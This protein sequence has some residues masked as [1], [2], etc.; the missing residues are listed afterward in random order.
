MYSM[1]RAITMKHSTKRSIL[2]FSISPTS[3]HR[4]SGQPPYSTAH[5]SPDCSGGLLRGCPHSTHCAVVC[6]LIPAL[7]RHRIPPAFGHPFRQGGLWAGRS[8]FGR[9]PGELCIARGYDDIR[10]GDGDEGKVGHFKRLHIVT[11]FL[12]ITNNPSLFGIEKGALH[13]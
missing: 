4:E 3:P 11:S 1:I 8:V 7:L 2:R 13:P 9:L 10:R 5:L 12:L 6:Q